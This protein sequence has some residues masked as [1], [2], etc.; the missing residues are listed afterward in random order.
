MAVADQSDSPREAGWTGSCLPNQ[1]FAPMAVERCGIS[2]RRAEYKSGSTEVV[3]DRF[4]STW[5]AICRRA[6]GRRHYNRL[7]QF[8]ANQRFTQ[9]IELLC[10]TGYRRGYQTRMAERLGVSRST[11]C[12]D[13]ARRER[14]RSVGCRRP[15]PSGGPA[16]FAVTFCLQ[17]AARRRCWQRSSPHLV[18]LAAPSGTAQ[19]S[20]DHGVRFVANSVD[21]DMD[22]PRRHDTLIGARSM[23]EAV[24]FSLWRP[25]PG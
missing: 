17:H 7:C 23:S 25:A 24:L 10:E 1:T 21:R 4:P 13:L 22:A 12:R 18:P 14:N 16:E 11:I 6:G 9:V 15:P 19:T 20:D 5:D 3:S 8:R 2:A